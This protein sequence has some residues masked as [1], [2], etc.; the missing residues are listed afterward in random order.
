M[1]TPAGAIDVCG[2]VYADLL[3]WHPHTVPNKQHTVQHY[4]ILVQQ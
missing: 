2:S 4:R 3:N 1:R